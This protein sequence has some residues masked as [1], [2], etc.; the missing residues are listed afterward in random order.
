MVSIAATLARPL[1]K[2]INRTE[3]AEA[4]VMMAGP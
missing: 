3:T 4:L 2:A 1:A